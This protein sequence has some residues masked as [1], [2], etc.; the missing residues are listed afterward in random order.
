MGRLGQEVIQLENI[1][2]PCR[3][4]KISF[5]MYFLNRYGVCESCEKGHRGNPKIFVRR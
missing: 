1:I 4:C 3:V 2:S 5:P